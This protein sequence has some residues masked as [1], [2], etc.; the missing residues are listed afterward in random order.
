[1]LPHAEAEEEELYA[2]VDEKTH[3]SLSTATMRKDHRELENRIGKLADL[4]GSDEDTIRRKLS[5]F[6]AI[7]LNH[8]HKEET[9]LV[10][11]LNETLS[12]EDFETLLDDVH[13]AEIRLHD[14]SS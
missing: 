14:D 11:F 6:S 1:M 2:A 8:F 5:E 12:C 3:N 10:P 7:L 9:F 4:K 13:E